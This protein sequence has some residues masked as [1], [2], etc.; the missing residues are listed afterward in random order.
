MR[1]HRIRQQYHSCPAP[2]VSDFVTTL[3]SEEPLFSKAWYSFPFCSRFF[4]KLG[5]FCLS[6]NDMYSGYGSGY[7]SKELR[8]SPV[9][10]TYLT[11]TKRLL[12][13]QKVLLTNT[14][15]SRG[16]QN[17]VP[18][19]KETPSQELRD[20]VF[21]RLYPTK[22]HRKHTEKFSTK[23]QNLENVSAKEICPQRKS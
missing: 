10:K 9:G 13:G 12:R 14:K 8:I 11:Q 4:Q 15:A 18:S 5:T 23:I 1:P 19:T 6:Q 21:T 2:V 20:A 22:E 17:Q 16:Q 3:K 7:S